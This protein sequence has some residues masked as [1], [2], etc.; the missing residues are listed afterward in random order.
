MKRLEELQRHNPEWT[1]WL[2]HVGTILRALDDPRWDEAVPHELAGGPLLTGAR[3]HVDR[4]VVAHLYENLMPHADADAFAVLRAAVNGDE[5]RLAALACDARTDPD[6]FRAV[7]ALLPMPFLHACARRWAAAIP[8]AWSKGFCP[9]CGHWPALAEICGV[10]RTRY[11]R[12]GHCGSAWRTQGLSCTYCAMTDHERLAS[13]IPQQGMAGTAVEV[14]NHCLGSLKVF[15][16]LRPCSSA[17][18]MLED[19]ASV[20]LD[21][22][23]AERGY[24]R[25]EG[26]GHGL[27]LKILEA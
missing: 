13:L 20:E 10:E 6:A 2:A 18:V 1:P 9:V 24:R 26:R 19:L 8:I 17:E 23:A 27:F 12:C 11:L 7:A 21:L 16:R 22:V 3:V 5:A 4:H 25:P 14:C 15:H